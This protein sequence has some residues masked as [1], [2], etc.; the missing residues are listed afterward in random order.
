MLKQGPGRRKPSDGSTCPTISVSRSATKK[1]QASPR[2][3]SL[4]YRIAFDAVC[5]VGVDAGDDLPTR[6]FDVLR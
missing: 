2:S 4:R 1:T 5:F 6:T 3:V